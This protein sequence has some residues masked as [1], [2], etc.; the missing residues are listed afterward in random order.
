MTKGQ[1]LHTVEALYHK[2][3]S[4]IYLHERNLDKSNLLKELEKLSVSK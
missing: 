2:I 3:Y 4:L 1:P